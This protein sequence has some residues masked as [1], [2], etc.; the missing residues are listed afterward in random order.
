M[1]TVSLFHQLRRSLSAN[2]LARKI[3]VADAKAIDVLCSVFHLDPTTTSSLTTIS[4]T[5][6]YLDHEHSYNIVSYDCR[7]ISGTRTSEAWTN[8]GVATNEVTLGR[9]A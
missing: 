9:Q 8:I 1:Y 6:S 4:P 7:I 3:N 5:T 2:L